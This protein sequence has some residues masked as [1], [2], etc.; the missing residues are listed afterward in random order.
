MFVY[1]IASLKLSF[2][3]SI[4]VIEICEALVVDN[5]VVDCDYGNNGGPNA[6]DTCDL[7]CDDGF[8]LTGSASRTCQVDGTWSGEP[9]LCSS[10]E[11]L[12]MRFAVSSYIYLELI[13]LVT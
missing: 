6:N 13:L 10:G 8:E 3:T 7:T 5:G 12:E 9:A 1:T 2:H 4:V 11:L